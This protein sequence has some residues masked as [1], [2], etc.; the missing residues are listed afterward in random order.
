MKIPDASHPITVTPTGRRVTVRVDG[1]TVADTT[2]A[3]TLQESTYSP[4]YY[5][6]LADVDRSLLRR[7]SHTTHCPYKGDASYYSVVTD[8]RELVDVIW[9][10]EAPYPAVAPIAGRVAFYADRVE[11]TVS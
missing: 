5:L 8:G 6:P 4:V 11:L 3:L 2:D 10:Y 7:T 9:T 1:V